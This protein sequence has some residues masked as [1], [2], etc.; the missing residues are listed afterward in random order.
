MRLNSFLKVTQISDV[1]N[2]LFFQLV[3]ILWLERV[4]LQGVEKGDSGSDVVRSWSLRTMSVH[5]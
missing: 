3:G 4:I 1:E 5:C 2:G